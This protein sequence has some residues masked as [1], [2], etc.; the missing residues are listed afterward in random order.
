[1]AP[2]LARLIATARPMPPPPP[3]TTQTRPARPSQSEEG[4]SVMSVSMSLL[5]L[6]PRRLTAD[7]NVKQP[8]R[9]A[10]TSF[11]A[12]IRRAIRLGV[13]PHHLLPSTSLMNGRRW[14]DARDGDRDP[15]CQLYRGP[16]RRVGGRID[17]SRTATSVSFRQTVIASAWWHT[18]GDTVVLMRRDC[19]H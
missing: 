12:G 5:C 18:D 13:H 1:C 6:R 16:G 15:Q 14:A 4:C 7:S 3:V 10:G 17:S 11:R 9:C 8:R 2:A 19:V